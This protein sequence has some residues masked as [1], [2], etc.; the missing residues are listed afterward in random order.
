MSFIARRD[1]M[2][3]LSALLISENTVNPSSPSTPSASPIPGNTRRP[4]PPSAKTIIHS[5]SSPINLATALP[6]NYVKDGSVDYTREV[7][8]VLD[9]LH[10]LGGGKIIM[11]AHLTLL[12]GN[13]VVYSNT[14]I[15][16]PS[17]TSVLKVKPGCM[18]ISVNPEVSGGKPV[19][20]VKNIH[21]SGFQI[22]G[23][24][25]TAKFSEHAHLL[26]LNALS[27]SLLENLLIKG[28]Q[29]DGI[30]LGYAT[31]GT[32]EIHNE[33]VT[34]RKVSIDGVNKDNRNGISIIDGSGILIEDADIFNCT[35]FNMPGAIDI[36]PDKNPHALI[37]NIE[38]RNTKIHNIG[39]NVGA[40]SLVL[41]GAS[42]ISAPGHITIDNVSV[43]GCASNAFTFQSQ[44]PAGAA[45]GPLCV[46]VSLKNSI[47]RNGHR[48]FTL[49]G[50]DGIK[51]DGNTFE[52]FDEAALIG[53]N[54]ATTK[55]A[56]VQL[57][58][59]I[60]RRCGKKGGTGLAI[61]SVSRLKIRDVFEDCGAGTFRRANAIEFKLGTSDNVDISGTTILSPTGKT[62]VA[63]KK[64]LG[65]FFTPKTNR[66]DNLSIGAL[67]NDFEVK[68]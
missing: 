63:I 39:G 51:M 11:P 44:K 28:F 4:A 67:D 40:I 24:V 3:F 46:D 32:R 53:Y 43:D 16:A 60:W 33:N 52:D 7:Q 29:G 19:D 47:A 9:H 26:N 20:N 12:V 64:S 48:P 34:I 62:K 25:V 57:S 30:Y 17:W 45:A 50:V 8:K 15:T 36:E 61:Y 54:T 23:A 2:K 49:T 22:A 1:F 21:L 5:K 6:G 10:D 27:D 14:E 42:Y 56:N 18:G 65:H 31:H 55:C 38:I 68:K 13:L 37:R 41:Q 66:A 59:K 58:N 35:R